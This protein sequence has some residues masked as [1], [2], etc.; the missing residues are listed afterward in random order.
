MVQ[1][2]VD[3]ANAVDL[4]NP[5]AK[6][7]GLGTRVRALEGTAL[8]ATGTEAQIPICGADGVPA[9]K[10]VSG[11]ITINTDGVTAIGAGKVTYDKLG[12]NTKKMVIDV[13]LAADGAA[14]DEYEKSV[15]VAPF[16]CTVSAVKMVT[17]SALGQAT[18]Y[19]TLSVV[20]KGHTD[21]SGTTAI[22][23]YAFDND[24]THASVAYVVK[25]LTLNGTPA[26]LDLAAGDVLVL[27]KAKTANGQVVPRSLLQLEVVRA[28]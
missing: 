21:G 14:A 6:R 23:S 11:D 22:A 12:P 13:G 26:N 20:N 19:A 15:F 3:E 24:T 27:K 25:E 7:V 17:E 10:S 16:A 4:M 2:T 28:A 5:P 1:L 18:N 8:P 9:Q